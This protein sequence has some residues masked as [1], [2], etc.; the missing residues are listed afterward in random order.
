MLHQILRRHSMSPIGEDIEMGRVAFAGKLRIRHLDIVIETDVPDTWRAL[1]RQR[2]LW[3]AGNFRHS[4][5]NFDRN[6]FQLR[7]W[8][9]YNLSILWMTL[10]FHVWS[11]TS[12]LLHPTLSLLAFGALVV[13]AAAITTLI[14][15]WQVRTPLMLIFPFYAVVQSALIFSVGALWYTRLLIRTRDLGRYRFGLR[16]TVLEPALPAPGWT[17]LATADAERDRRKPR[18]PT[19]RTTPVSVGPTVTTLAFALTRP[20]CMSAAA[21]VGAVELRIAARS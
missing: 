10:H 19:P 7:W 17:R 12:A 20:S 21:G 5:V 18:R 11:Y 6:A 9:L 3:W 8:T 2:R 16:R 1:L 15:N 4:F 14:A 13:A